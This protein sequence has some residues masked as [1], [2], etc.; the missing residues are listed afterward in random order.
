MNFWRFSSLVFICQKYG[1]S[2]TPI[3][4]RSDQESGSWH[5]CSSGFLQGAITQPLLAGQPTRPW[6]GHSSSTQPPKSIQS[7][8]WTPLNYL[9]NGNTECRVF[10]RCKWQLRYTGEVDPCWIYRRKT[11]TWIWWLSTPPTLLP[12]FT[13]N[14]YS[15]A[16]QAGQRNIMQRRDYV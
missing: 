13:S 16:G 4:M 5:L 1:I 7:R 11:A 10:V 3:V 12:H 14:S 6:E 2:K 15:S 8:C 9:V